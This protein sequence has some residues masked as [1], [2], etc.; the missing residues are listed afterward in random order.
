[1]PKKKIITE[2]KW[3]D[4]D[5]IPPLDEA[6]FESADYYEGGKLVRPG[7]PKMD[8]PKQALNIRLD[9][10]VLEHFRATGPGW[11]TRINDALRKAAGLKARK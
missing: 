5:E 11:Q 6:W 2:S 10:D 8:D 4:P 1:M 7:R 3:V 9:A